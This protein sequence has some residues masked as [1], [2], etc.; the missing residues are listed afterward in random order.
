RHRDN[1][2]SL[3]SPTRRASD[4]SIRVPV[5]KVDHIIN[6]VGELI[7]TQSMLTQA[8]NE[9]SGVRSDALSGGITLLQRNAR[10]L[11][12]AVMSIRMRSEEHTSELQSREKLVCR[13]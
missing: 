6:L 2:R 12:E 8:V 10:D 7:I 5:D 3:C 13:L 9:L 1:R 4:L 11:Q